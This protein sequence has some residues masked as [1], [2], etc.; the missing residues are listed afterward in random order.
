M[1]DVEYNGA[2]LNGGSHTITPGTHDLPATGT[3]INIDVSA[4]DATATAEWYNQA[5]TLL[6]SLSGVPHDTDTPVPDPLTNA[7]FEGRTQVLVY[8]VGETSGA[9]LEGPSRFNDGTGDVIYFD[10]DQ[11]APDFPDITNITAPN[12]N[13][14]L[15]VVGNRGRVEFNSSSFYAAPV[16]QIDGNLVNIPDNA[17][18][19]PSGE[20]YATVIVDIVPVSAGSIGPLTSPVTTNTQPYPIPVPVGV[21]PPPLNPAA[22]GDFTITIDFTGVADGTYELRFSARDVVGRSSPPVTEPTSTIVT[23]VLDR[24]NPSVD[25]TA[26]ESPFI[27]GPTPPYSIA[28]EDGVFTVSGTVSEPYNSPAT[29]TLEVHEGDA[30]WALLAT[31]TNETLAAAPPQPWSTEVNLSTTGPGGIPAAVPPAGGQEMWVIAATARDSV[32]N[33]SRT[34]DHLY[35]VYDLAPPEPPDVSLPYDG[36]ATAGDSLPVSAVV[37]NILAPGLETLEEQGSLLVEA[38]IYSADDPTIRTTYTLPGVPSA[39]L[40]DSALD[41]TAAFPI[42]TDPLGDIPDYF[43][44]DGVLPLDGFPDGRLVVEFTAIDQVGNRSPVVTV[45]FA[46]GD[47]GPSLDIDLVHSGPDD[48]YDIPSQAPLGQPPNQY[49]AD[50]RIFVISMRSPE[51]EDR[52]V[53]PGVIPVPFPPAPANHDPGTSA[54]LLIS[55]TF[56]D[57]VTNVVEITAFGANIPTTSVPISPPITSGAFGIEIDVRFLPEGVPQLVNLQG[58]NELGQRGEIETVVVIRDTVP[59]RAP[60]IT[61]PASQPYFTTTDTMVLEGYAEPY[62]LVAVLTPPTTGSFAVP[63]PATR[64]ALSGGVPFVP[65]TRSQFNTIPASAQTTRCDSTGFFRFPSLE[66]STVS[67]SYLDPTTLLVQAIDVYDNTDPDFSVTPLEV[68]RNPNPG[69]IVRVVIDEDASRAIEVFPAAPTVPPTAGQFRAIETVWIS[70]D[71]DT[72][73]TTPPD[74]AV[75]QHDASPVRASLVYPASDTPVTTMSVIY[76]YQVLDEPARYDGEV[77]LSFSGGMDVFGNVISPLDI[78]HAF[79]VDSVAPVPAVTTPQA[80]LPAT[81]ETT[82]AVT[83]IAADLADLPPSG[84]S[85]CSGLSTLFTTIELYG[86]LEQDPDAAAPLVPSTPPAPYDVAGEPASPLLT[87]GHYRI[88]VHAVDEVGNEAIYYSNFELD[89]T[90]VP[91][92]RLVFHPACGSAVSSLPAIDGSTGVWVEVLDARIDASLSTLEL[93]RSDSSPVSVTQETS[94]ASIIMARPVPPFADDGS[95]DGLYVMRA[96]IVDEAGN[97]AAPVT[98]AFVFDTTP[99]SYFSFFPDPSTCVNDPLRKVQVEI[100]DPPSPAT[101]DPYTAGVDLERCTMELYLAEPHWPNRTPGGTRLETRLRLIRVPGE[102]FDTLCLDIL[103]E[104]GRVRSLASDGTE[105]GTYEIVVHAVDRAGNSTEAREYFHYDTQ[106]P[107]VVID[108][109]PERSFFADGT[110]TI[111]GR[112]YDLG[113]CGFDGTSTPSTTYPTRAVQIRLQK[114]DSAGNPLPPTSPWIDWTAV[115]TLD[116]L[117]TSNPLLTDYASWSFTGSIPDED[118]EALLSVRVADTAGNE[119]VITRRVHVRKDVLDAPVPLYPGDS[120]VVPFKVL[121]FRWKPYADASRY[122]L[123]LIRVTPSSV[124]TSTTF[125]VPYPVSRYLLDL[126]G[127]VETSN[128]G[129]PLTSATVFQWRI[130]AFDVSSNAGAWSST[131][132]FIVDP[133]PPRVLDVWINGVSAVSSPVLT[134][135]VNTVRIDFLEDTGMDFSTHP[136]V[137]VELPST[138]A[139]LSFSPTTWTSISWSGTLFLETPYDRD[140]DGTAI[141]RIRG[142]RDLAGNEAPMYT[143]T[144]T[145]D[146]GLWVDVDF[147]PNVVD[148][149]DLLFQIVVREREGGEPAAAETPS[150]MVR[151]ASM[152]SWVN[153]SVRPI[154]AS[155][156]AG[157][158]WYGRFRVDPGRLGVMEWRVEV[159]PEA[160][161]ASTTRI[162][163]MSIAHV[164]EKQGIVFSA[165]SPDSQLAVPPGALKGD[166]Y[167]YALGPSAVSALRSAGASASTTGL[168][169]VRVV[170]AYLPASVPLRGEALLHVPLE[171]GERNLCASGALG[172][173]RLEGGRWRWCG[174]TPDGGGLSCRLRSLGV[175]ALVRDCAPPALAPG[176]VSFDPGTGRLECTFTDD[177]SGLDPSSPRLMLP[178]GRELEPSSVGEGGTVSWRLSASAASAL[179]AASS[180]G[181]RVRVADRAGNSAVLPLAVSKGPLLVISEAVAY[182]NPAS[183]RLWIRYRLSSAASS[184]YVKIYDAAGRRIRMLTGAPSGAGAWKVG[185]DLRD[186]RGRLVSNGVYFFKVCAVDP[187]GRLVSRKGKIAVLR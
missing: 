64:S 97:P 114:L 162:V 51:T 137:E 21:W 1:D 186:S 45:T 166:T 33:V 148:P 127:W 150:V 185:W 135:G 38:V 26:P 140:I 44:I 163:T 167:L 143:T 172:V 35:V 90:P 136:S 138:S 36:Y 128:G 152:S 159:R 146:S 182:P 6:N 154:G 177:G 41:D 101:T 28:Y 24:S 55:G 178:D 91:P 40:H 17:F 180:L 103:D 129:S 23:V 179:S 58:V 86:P 59:A 70:V 19:A 171:E 147:F 53:P 89:L 100:G 120:A 107:R 46:K 83:T 133:T 61:S 25:I 130:R 12:G 10:A 16:V 110:F 95:D 54:T 11:G 117:A 142:A 170:G 84:V 116:A 4:P 155:T 106:H 122:D 125:A 108:S 173:A 15:I 34:S 174:G 31:Y 113:P 81:G 176:G 160:G 92:W 42:F 156:P 2:E 82:F 80:F 126:P 165:A 72:P 161:G 8:G 66:I 43:V 153:A 183:S 93:L 99:P 98:C 85:T 29:V 75:T 78:T 123:E 13:A 132:T 76:Q 157:C 22:P 149:L 7:L 88:V 131:A 169:V 27:I 102:P 5:G 63:I 112:A 3:M 96:V 158:A 184:V 181:T 74:L 141:L 68:F 115:D 111:T 134:A 18:A 50:D 175:L 60:V 139:A 39:D 69:N 118:A 67:T 144:V 119:T 32:G 79:F 145:V 14:S 121:E 164:M 65:D 109:F 105:D 187:G 151:Q 124:T 20:V 87:D 94:G 71:F 37:T 168:E 52:G 47:A 48:N 30:G 62:A 73:V 56:S 9:W 104:R 77:T 49:G 57:I